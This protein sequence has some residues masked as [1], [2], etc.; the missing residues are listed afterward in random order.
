MKKIGL[1]SRKLLRKI[2]GGVSFIAIVFIFSGAE[3]ESDPFYDIRLTGT[4]KLKSANIP[5]EK[6]RVVVNEGFA[7]GLT[8]KKG[9]FDFY[10]SIPKDPYYD[11]S[12]IRY[13]LDSVKVH[14]LDDKGNFSD[15]TMIV[16]PI[17]KNEVIIHAELE[18]K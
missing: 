3:C 10:A 1:K 15:K 12:N 17:G 14:F 9:K 16:N 8:D 6:I 5:I 18:E 2:L 11:N 7:Y 13:S 4:V